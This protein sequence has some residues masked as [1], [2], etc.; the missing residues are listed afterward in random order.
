MRGL[1]PHLLVQADQSR[2]RQRR[3]R[4]PAGEGPLL[5]RR[6]FPHGGPSSTVPWRSASTVEVS[7]RRAVIR[8]FIDAPD[9]LGVVYAM[10]AITESARR[11]HDRDRRRS[12]CRSPQEPVR[13]G[14]TGGA[15]AAGYRANGRH[16]RLRY[17]LRVRVHRI[18]ASSSPRD[19]RRAL[20]RAVFLTGHHDH[21][22]CAGVN[23]VA[24]NLGLRCWRETL[25]ARLSA[26]DRRFVAPMSAIAIIATLNG[27]VV[28]HGVAGRCM[29][30][31]E[32]QPP[33]APAANSA[34]AAGGVLALRCCSGDPVIT[35]RIT[36]IVFRARQSR[37]SSSS[38][39]RP[40]PDIV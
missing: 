13:Y 28:H 2:A 27:I 37:S 31:P 14:I 18:R 17:W 7:A 29:G 1:V 40:P 10:A 38:S 25:G 30:F 22:L 9:A 33:G 35:A 5:V 12:L 23:G 15:D 16:L 11:T 32:W 20:P 4:R 3:P 19:V 39:A 34:L 6:S 21:S 8:V 36:L 24:E 26:S